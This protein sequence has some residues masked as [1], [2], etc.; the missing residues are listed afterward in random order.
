MA[1][2][3]S[4]VEVLSTR[5]AS[6]DRAMADRG[7]LPAAAGSLVPFVLTLPAREEEEAERAGRAYEENEGADGRE[8]AWAAA[9]GS[10]DE[11]RSLHRWHCDAA[12]AVV[13][14]QGTVRRAVAVADEFETESIAS[15]E[16]ASHESLV[17]YGSDS[18]G[19]EKKGKK[20]KKHKEGRTGKN[21]VE[22]GAVSLEDAEAAHA[23]AEQEAEAVLHSLRLELGALP[24]KT[25]RVFAALRFEQQQLCAAQRLSRNQDL[26]RAEHIALE[27]EVWPALV[28]ASAEPPTVR[29]RRANVKRVGGGAPPATAFR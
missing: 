14:T 19:G 22:A 27:A 9:S 7:A 29:R 15:A 5:L 8:A 25:A 6:A 26:L 11:L 4:L 13:S 23:L 18:G 16:F 10:L 21:E 28:A 3:K 24:A 20:G 1:E 17:E 12:A 2:I